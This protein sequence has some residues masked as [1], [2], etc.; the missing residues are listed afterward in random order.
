MRRSNLALSAAVVAATALCAAVPAQAA[1]PATPYSISALTAKPG[2]GV[3]EVTLNW[4]HNGAKTTS[5]LL[6][7]GLNAFSKSASSSLPTSG[8]HATFF[9]F[10]KSARTATLTTAQ[11]AQAGAAVQT[12]NHLYFRLAAV[13]KDA[14]GATTKRYYPYLQAVLPRPQ[15]PRAGSTVRI[16]SFNV[17]TA[18]ALTDPRTWLER[19][20]DVARQI[21]AYKPHV[22]AVQELGPG[23]A[24]GVSGTLQGNIRQTDSLLKELDKVYGQKYDLVRTTP[25]VAP[26]TPT[27]SQGMR[28][29]Y[30]NTRYRLASSCPETTSGRSYSSSCSFQVPILSTDS[31]EKRRRVAYAKFEDKAT[32]KKFWF[33]SVHLD[34]RHSS[35][36]STEVK[37][38]A[39]RASQGRTVVNKM[40]ELNTEKLPI[41]VGGDFNSWSTSAVGNG[42]HDVLVDDGY[43]DTSAAVTRKNFQYKTINDWA[44]TMTAAAQGVGV[45]ID[46]LMVKGAP[47]SSYFENVMKVTDENRPSDHN[48]IISDIVPFASSTDTNSTTWREATLRGTSRG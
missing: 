4:T 24:D 44:L 40:N 42:A 19:A 48:M 11:L 9:T 7:T 8:R 15:A 38:D 12:G 13:N 35:T 31:E 16:S 1:A 2:P 29:L 21:V 46:M 3:G 47:G 23:R 33:V 45:R 27:D 39:L 14:S 25:Y 20:P 34:A 32:G 41:I 26:G 17:R 28:I 37:Y 36:R 22:V 43:Y 30:D 6:E 18:R 10:G 5:F